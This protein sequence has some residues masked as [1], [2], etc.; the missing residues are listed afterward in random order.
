MGIKG[1]NRYRGRTAKWR[2]ALAVFFI[3][4]I[5]AAVIVMVLQKYVVY[6]D[7]G[8][9]QLKLPFEKETVEDVPQE[10][11]EV[12]IIY[13]ETSKKLLQTAVRAAS[14]PG[15]ALTVQAW[16]EL[17]EALA[18]EET[19]Y[20]AVALTLKDGAGR[21]YYDSSAA[22]SSSVRLAE[23]TAQAL[24][25]VL[26]GEYYTIACMDCFHDPKA[27]NFQVETMGLKNTGGYIFYDGNNSQWLD[28]SKPEAV[29][30]LLRLLEEAADM[31]FDEILLT[32]VS[33][34]AVGKL[35]KI[36][37]GT[38]DKSRQLA[39][40]LQEA[41]L[42]VGEDV[43]LSVEVSAETAKEG[44][45]AVTGESLAEVCAVADRIYVP[46]ADAAEA[47]TLVETGDVQGVRLVPILPAGTVYAGENVLIDG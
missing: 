26:A 4:V 30:Y 40:F 27:A 18:A 44:V 42:R 31:G 24:E 45:N 9:P 34:P 23:D 47:A 28:P 13:G 16:R 32:S 19:A 3:L 41:K 20:N 10:V 14:L 8:A 21:V 5:I 22:V 43:V 15:G 11:P 12:E 33:Y 37:Y 17:Q 35:D 25:A 36:D 6:D 7:T 46:V 29:E 39:A 38:E 1:Y 2:T